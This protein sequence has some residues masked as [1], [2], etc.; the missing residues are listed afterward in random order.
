MKNQTKKLAL[1]L[2]ML[3]MI[4]AAT[5]SIPNVQAASKVKLNK[6]SV[7]LQKGKSITLK[8]KSVKKNK[9]KWSSNK[10]KVASVTQKG[11]VTGRRVGTAKITAKVGTKKY[12]CKVKVIKKQEETPQPQ[13]TDNT[14]EVMEVRTIGDYKYRMDYDGNSIWIIGYNGTNPNVIIPSEVEGYPVKVVTGDV[15]RNNTTIVSVIIP[16][17]IVRIGNIC[18][19]C[20][21]LTSVVVP[22]SVTEIEGAFFECP[23]LVVSVYT[24][25]YAVTYMYSNYID[26]KIVGTDKI[27]HPGSVIKY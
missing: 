13:E 20:P 23:N 7:T 1:L 11:K 22:A 16:D 15:F 2:L 10:K 21:N 17:G 5:I 4:L 3:C 24:G 8:L 6:T 12:S 19:N 9:V 18:L 25:S 27:I 14:W 26:Y